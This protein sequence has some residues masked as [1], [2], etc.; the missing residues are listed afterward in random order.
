MVSSPIWNK[1]NGPCI[2]AMGARAHFGSG[3]LTGWL[4][5]QSGW[6]GATVLIAKGFSGVCNSLFG[7][8]FK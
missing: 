7:V 8:A 3:S 1:S 2:G 6:F 5:A 4:S